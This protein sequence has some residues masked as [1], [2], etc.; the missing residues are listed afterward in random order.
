MRGCVACL[1]PTNR[2]CLSKASTLTASGDG[3][4]GHKGG[5]G[6]LMGWSVPSP[7]ARL[8][9]SGHSVRS[10]KSKGAPACC[11]EF[12]PTAVDKGIE[13]D[14]AYV[15]LASE[16]TSQGLD[17]HR[18]GHYWHRAG[19]GSVTKAIRPRLGPGWRAGWTQ[20]VDVSQR[21]QARLRR[22]FSAR[23]GARCS[24]QSHRVGV[25]GV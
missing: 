20:H 3:L 11:G 8:L 17:R 4:T 25:A 23:E 24:G 9:A 7:G 12:V 6:A 19:V 14:V 22:T 16:P 15:P 2:C 18:T 1:P 10:G 13:A 5:L 21:V